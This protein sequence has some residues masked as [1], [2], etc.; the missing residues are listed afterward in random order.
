MIAPVSHLTR[1][2]VETLEQIFLYL[3]GRDI[4]RMEAVRGAVANLR[5][6]RF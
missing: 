4:I 2:P 3:P 5:A 6:M 1:L